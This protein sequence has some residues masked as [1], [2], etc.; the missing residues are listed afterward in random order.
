MH[1]ERKIYLAA[2]LVIAFGLGNSQIRK[3]MNWFERV[4]GRVGCVA[5]SVSDRAIGGET[6]VENLAERV[7]SR[8]QNRIGQGQTALARVQ[9]KVACAQ[10]RMAQ[11]QAEVDRVQAERARVITLHEMRP[12]VTLERQQA[13]GNILHQTTPSNDDRI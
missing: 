12:T 9:V 8:G 1:S 3:H 5:N 2:I 10:S 13:V 11:R 4:S 7:F 6:L